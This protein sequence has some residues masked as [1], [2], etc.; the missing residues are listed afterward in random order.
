MQ[1]HFENIDYMPSAVHSNIG[2]TIYL[3]IGEYCFPEENWYDYASLIMEQWIPALTS[4]AHGSTDVCKLSFWDGP[5]FVLLKRSGKSAAVSCFYDQKPVIE[6][7][8]IA[9]HDFLISVIKSGNLYCRLL[10]LQ[11]IDNLQVSAALQKLKQEIRTVREVGP[12]Q[13]F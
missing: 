5:C 1:L 13:G 6:D 12:Y 11:G 8:L 2:G 3:T 10:H 9:L 7:T 4:F